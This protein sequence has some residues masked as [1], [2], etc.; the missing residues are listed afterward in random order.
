MRVAVDGPYNEP[1]TVRFN[2]EDPANALPFSDFSRPDNRPL[3]GDIYADWQI[4][5]SDHWNLGETR[6]SPSLAQIV[7]AIVNRSD[8]ASGNALA[9]ITQTTATPGGPGGHRRVLAYE[10]SWSNGKARLIITYRVLGEPNLMALRALTPPAI[11]GTLNDWGQWT[12]ILLDKDTAEAVWFQPPQVSPPTPEDSSAS[13]RA[14]WDS[15]DL[16]I[17]VQVRDDVIVND[18]SDVWRDDEIELA[19][20]GA[21][22][23]D[24]DGGDTHQDTVNADGRITDFVDP[25]H[26]VPIQ[27]AAVPVAGGWNVEVRIPA[28]HLFGLNTLLIAGKTMAF[29]LGLHDD[30]DGGNWD[31][32]MIWAGDSTSYHAGGLLRLDDVVAPT[33]LPTSTPTSTPTATSTPTRTATPTATATRTATPTRTPTASASPTQTPTANSTWTATPTRTPTTMPTATATATP[34]STSAVRHRYLPLILRH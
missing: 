29:D 27:A 31:S 34:T 18:S 9:I 24:P 2:G 3:I 22:D 33:P 6:T 12:P 14:L 7:Q 30:D 32:H 21:Y 1:M 5:S 23:F 4:P 10:R 11:D 16:Y 28:T 8:W 19:F 25:A 17:A 13:L 26:P 20:V 15:S